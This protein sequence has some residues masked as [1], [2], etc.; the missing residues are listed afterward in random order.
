MMVNTSQAMPMMIHSGIAITSPMPR[1]STASRNST[2]NAM[3]TV[4]LKLSA[5]LPWSSTN[6]IV[7]FLTSQMISGPMKQPMLPAQPEVRMPPTS[8]DRCANIA[9]WRSSAPGV[10]DATGGGSGGGVAVSLES[11]MVAPCSRGE[12]GPAAPAQSEDTS[13]PPVQGHSDAG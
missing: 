7:S 6:G 5:S 13:V 4:M 3:P 8:A 12:G 11:V 1:V 10:P 2:K 9:H